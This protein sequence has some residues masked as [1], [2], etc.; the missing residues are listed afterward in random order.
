M[1]QSE[2]DPTVFAKI[3]KCLA[4]AKSGNP[5]EAATALRQ[6]RALME[7]YNV[8]ECAI[9]RSEIGESR[10]DSTTMSRDKPAKWE[11]ALMSLIGRAFGCRLMLSRYEMSKG[12][13]N[14]GSYVFVGL[15][16]QAEVASYAAEV[17]IRK[18]KTARQKWLTDNVGGFCLGVP[19]AKAKKTRMGDAFA[20]GWV[21][22]IGRVVTDFANPPEISAAIDSH[23]EA[24]GSG[25]PA[26]CRGIAKKDIGRAELIAARS[27][28]EE[29]KKESLFRPVAGGGDNP[30]PLIGMVRP[31]LGFRA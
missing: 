23:I 13:A 24:K 30:D 4:L 31:Q 27:G 6:A 3:R 20:E 10:V 19:G 8:S 12:Y 21:S 28:M 22:S 2:L 15:K 16:Q 9:A 25:N 7:K 14:E 26:P 18:C 1:A 5:N 29:A 11:M 17:L